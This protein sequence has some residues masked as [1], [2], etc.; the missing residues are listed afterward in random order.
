MFH[1]LKIPNIGN[2]RLK[3]AVFTQNTNIKS[4]MREPNMLPENNFVE[5]F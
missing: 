5:F 1:A 3:L 4:Y 2:A